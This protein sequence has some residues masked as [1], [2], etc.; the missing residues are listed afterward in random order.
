MDVR[1]A[2]YLADETVESWAAVMVLTKVEEKVVK[3]AVLL[4][5]QLAGLTVESMAA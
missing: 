5:C 1:K 4:V 2:A 3:T